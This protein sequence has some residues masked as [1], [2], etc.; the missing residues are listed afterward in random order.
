MIKIQLPKF[1][2]TYMEFF[3]LKVILINYYN[4]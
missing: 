1:H 2:E 4:F 3:F